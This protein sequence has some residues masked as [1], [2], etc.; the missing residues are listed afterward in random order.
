M[1]VLIVLI[2][3]SSGIILFK[4]IGGLYIFKE[5]LSPKIVGKD[6]ILAIKFVLSTLKQSFPSCGT[7]LTEGSRFESTFNF[8]IKDAESTDGILPLF[9]VSKLDLKLTPSP[10]ST[11]SKYTS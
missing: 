6:E 10:F 9:W 1:A 3:L 4:V 8:E 11:N 7:S 2:L 5:I